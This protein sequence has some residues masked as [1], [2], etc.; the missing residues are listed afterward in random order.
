MAKTVRLKKGLDIGISGAAS[1]PT[2]GN[3][4]CVMPKAC[5]MTADDF[6]GLVLKVDVKEGDAVSVGSP[7]MHDKKYPDIKIVSPV[8][9]T[10]EAVERGERRKL[11]RIVVKPSD[12]AKVS[13]QEAKVREG[14]VPS[15]RVKAQQMLLDSGLWAQLRQRPY[16]Y[17]PV[18]GVAPRSIMITTFDSAPLAPDFSP[19][20]SGREEWAEAAVKTLSLLCDGKIYIG[21]RD[22]SP[23]AGINGAE[24]VV[25]E[26]PHPAGNAGVQIANVEPVDKGDVVWTLDA[27]TLLRIGR[28]ASEG[29]LSYSTVAAVCGCR[30]ASP[31]MVETVC[32]ADMESVAGG[33]LDHDGAH[34]RLLSGNVLTGIPT[35]R[36]MYMRYPYY[37]AT[38]ISEGDDRVEFM[39]WASM[40]ACKMSESRSFPGHFLRRRGGFCPDARLNGGRRAMIMSG[41]YDRYLPMDVMVEFLIKACIARD[42]DLMEQLGIYEVVPEDLALCEYADPSKLE[43]QRILRESLD[44]LYNELN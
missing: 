2:H 4:V 9:G 10:V 37:Q 6:P 18:P 40:S 25:V 19:L 12:G 39:G 38:A 23:F 31:A 24:T 29:V 20:A 36:D 17:V 13:S 21:V 34:I 14:G 28:L 35:G 22:G 26:G 1:W 15:D 8:S 30:V 44:Y 43:L 27:L 5:A 16:G 32:G 42:I 7:L 33:R 41:I 11:L 3:P